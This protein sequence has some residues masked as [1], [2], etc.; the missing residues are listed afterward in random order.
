[1]YCTAGFKTAGYSFFS[2]K[3]FFTTDYYFYL[4]RTDRCYVLS[5]PS[6]CSKTVAY[7]VYFMICEGCK[8]SNPEIWREVLY[9]VR[10]LAMVLE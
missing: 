8:D 4:L 5:L 1:M 7:V 6:L 3:E 2:G 9:A 10:N